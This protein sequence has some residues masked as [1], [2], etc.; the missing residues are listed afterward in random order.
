MYLERY[1][2]PVATGRATYTQNGVFGIEGMTKPD[3]EKLLTPQQV[4][5]RFAV[6]PKTVTRWARTGKLPCIKTPGGH[7]RYRASVIEEFAIE[8]YEKDSDS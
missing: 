4:A 2:S 7:R 6:D 8:G 3:P 1:A 5:D